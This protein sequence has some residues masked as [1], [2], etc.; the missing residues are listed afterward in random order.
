MSPQ[1]PSINRRTWAASGV[2]LVL[3]VACY[4]NV[5]FQPGLI[6]GDDSVASFYHFLTFAKSEM[7]AGRLPWWC[8]H[9]YCGV[10]FIASLMAPVFHPT[11]L[12]FLA[13]PVQV[14]YHLSIVL[15]SWVA[16]TF[17][18]MYLRLMR[19]HWSS[20]LI[21]SLALIFSGWVVT[22]A[23]HYARLQTFLHLPVVLYFL[24]KALRDRRWTW[25]AL[26]GVAAALQVH[27]S[28]V[29]MAFY[30]HV[31]V[32]SYLAARLLGRAMGPE[33]KRLRH[34]IV[35]V[36][37]AAVVAVGL[38]APLVLPT[39]AFLPEATRA[40][41]AYDF[42][43]G[44]SLPPE[45][46]AE[47][48]M[49]N[50]FGYWVNSRGFVFR[51]DKQTPYY[52]GNLDGP[53]LQADY[54]GMLTC[55]LALV[56]AL[57]SRRRLKWF[58]VAAAL[59]TVLV[60]LGRFTPVHSL[61]WRAVPVL[62]MFRAPAKW[63]FVATFPISLLAALGWEVAFQCP[64]PATRRRVRYT[65]VL[66]AA[67]CAVAAAS[68]VVAWRAH[69]DTLTRYFKIPVGPSPAKHAVAVLR[70][71]GWPE[72]TAHVTRTLVALA[73]WG[74]VTAGAIVVAMLAQGRWAVVACVGVVGVFLADLWTL[75]GPFLTNCPADSALLREEKLTEVLRAHR[76]SR[77]LFTPRTFRLFP[78]KALTCGIDTIDGYLPYGS[79]RF[80]QFTMP[81]R[82]S[83][84]KQ[85]LNFLSV[86]LIA[87]QAVKRVKAG[88]ALYDSAR[89]DRERPPFPPAPPERDG[90][91][92]HRQPVTVVRNP[93]AMPRAFLATSAVVLKPDVA[94]R[95]IASGRIDLSKT[96]V[97]DQRPG[98]AAQ[99]APGRPAPVRTMKFD[100]AERVMRTRC[101]SPAFLVT[102]ETFDR[103]WHATV[104]GV[105]APVLRAN[106][107]FQAVPVPAGEHEV[108]LF[109]RP[110]LWHAGL[111]GA[112]AGALLVLVAVA[113]DA[114]SNRRRRGRGGAKPNAGVSSVRGRRIRANDRAVSALHA[115]GI[116]AQGGCRQLWRRAHGHRGYVRSV[117]YTHGGTRL[118]SSADGGS[119]CVWQV[120]GQ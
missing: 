63:L 29:E 102:S 32:A 74:G 81:S 19:L 78:N 73:I 68:G 58:C 13:L 114:S 118:L 28:H 90:W 65:L 71:E 89:D 1:T 54:L 57:F 3:V 42:S 101:P 47:L 108:R 15:A 92:V 120:P 83:R 5:L 91:L 48:F 75:E 9:I 111:A 8:P 115:H 59:A 38:A 107:A 50:P 44:G 80:R 93:Q 98:I 2:I 25:Y 55:L 14:A 94:L 43:A 97:L 16:G 103:G 18:Y 27:M 100:A 66:A 77:Y 106:Y 105:P 20:A 23:Y 6:V 37:L 79:S 39:M 21:G 109:Y 40:G 52:W 85:M 11:M 26:A 41:R 22:D 35:G 113:V 31:M 117:A 67:V 95:Q 72:I 61:F 87:T 99:P 60:A 24:E 69:R 64:D 88:A 17:A 12:L 116:A 51:P 49:R 119:I 62:A 7:H 104:N 33:P 96:V 82:W 56:G 112:G 30:S 4:R 45:E 34:A 86:E 70:H 84:P 10:P 36:L 46:L 76:P 53:R 110:P